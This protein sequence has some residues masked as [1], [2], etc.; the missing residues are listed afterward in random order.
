[1]GDVTGPQSQQHGDIGTFV[2][3]GFAILLLLAASVVSILRPA[4]IEEPTVPETADRVDAPAPVQETA[5]AE[6]VTDT[7]P[8][9][10]GVPTV[11]A[12]RVVRTEP[13][14]P[15]PAQIDTRVGE[16]VHTGSVNGQLLI[17]GRESTTAIPYGEPF[18]V[19]WNTDAPSGCYGYGQNILRA[20]G[21]SW[22]DQPNL[23]S[24]GTSKLI[25]RT[26]GPGYTSELYLGFGCANEQGIQSTWALR[27]PVTPE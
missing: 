16:V 1:M 24:S 5:P 21:G 3:V 22:N 23:L 17:N 18:I 10:T 11:P 25:A 27:I 19:T 26:V 8:V 12:P 20:D 9:T 6:T 13:P 14:V 2:I 4:P 15:A 7:P